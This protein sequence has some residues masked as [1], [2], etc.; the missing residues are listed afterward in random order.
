MSVVGY[1]CSDIGDELIIENNFPILGANSIISY[2]DVINGVT[3]TR[4]FDKYFQYS[5]DN[6]LN[7]SEWIILN[8]LNL[9]LIQLK[10]GHIFLIRY[11]YIR[12][13]SDTTQL[14]EYVSSELNIDYSNPEVPD[15]F[16]ITNIS[17]FIE[18]INVDN[19]NYTVSLLAKVYDREIIASY[20]QRGFND[21]WEDEDYINFWYTLIVILSIIVN[22]SR[23]LL[24]LPYDI[25][26]MYD[27]LKSRGIFLNQNK[28]LEKLTYICNNFF[29]EI[30]K[31]GTNAIIHKK[32]SSEYVD[33]ELL[34]LINYKQGDEFLFVHSNFDGGWIMG[35]NSPT[36]RGVR[37]FTNISKG[38]EK[39][40]DVKDLTVYPLFGEEYI[41]N[42][43]DG[44]RY[45]M[46]IGN[47]T[48]SG[49][50]DSLKLIG[51]KYFT[52]DITKLITIDQNVDY[53]MSFYLKVKSSLA[54]DIRI[55][56]FNEFG[57]LLNNSFK[58]AVN[59]ELSNVFFIRNMPIIDEY[60]FFSC[61]IYSSNKID[62]DTENI[63]YGT[64][65]NL[66]FYDPRVKKICPF[67]IGYSEVG[68]GAYLYDF[69]FRPLN[70]TKTTCFLG[71]NDFSLL[72]YKNN[73]KELTNEKIEDNMID[74]L[75]PYNTRLITERL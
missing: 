56:G 63:M 38:Y 61:K 65:N 16:N 58:S 17:N 30:S 74:Y 32:N 25:D 6:G 15:F 28:D 53:E 40:R 46:N 5:I 50:R 49:I 26:M 13:G 24:Y 75:L 59:E 60:L 47:N 36:F 37:H 12:S 42:I 69:K 55:Y 51:T 68:E 2:V 35:K 14:L 21:N 7:F 1:T 10:E 19:L 67:I 62:Y 66:R 44:E 3:D 45:V 72:Y 48:Y 70:T 64:G 11:K 71:V 57:E 27:Y 52:N 33:G 20:I 22:F 8:D 34:R 73:N 9:S 23:K 54:I 41:N 4:Y 18:F 43:Q 39:T 29:R 31:R